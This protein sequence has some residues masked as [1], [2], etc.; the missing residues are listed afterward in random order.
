VYSEGIWLLCRCDWEWRQTTQWLCIAARQ[1]REASTVAR[2]PYCTSPFFNSLFYDCKAVYSVT[3][4][5]VILT[6]YVIF[7]LC[8][9]SVVLYPATALRKR[10]SAG[11]LSF[12][13]FQ[14]V[15]LLK[16]CRAVDCYMNT[17]LQFIGFNIKLVY[18]TK[19]TLPDLKSEGNHAEECLQT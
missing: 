13:S 11:Q 7:S 3:L 10:I 12:F 6:F 2:Y 4:T 8:L 17:N 16:F 1:C 19:Q 14:L 15:C 5:A 9:W 18:I